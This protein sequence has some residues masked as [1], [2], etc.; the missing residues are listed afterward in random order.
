[1]VCLYRIWGEAHGRMGDGK[2]KCNIRRYEA[3]CFRDRKAPFCGT[4][5]VDILG[6]KK[7]TEEEMEDGSRAESGTESAEQSD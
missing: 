7:K 1:M 4:C 5:L 3:C 6:K 2:M